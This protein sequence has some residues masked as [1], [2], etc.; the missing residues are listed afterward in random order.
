MGRDREILE[1]EEEGTGEGGKGV[2]KR[3]EGRDLKSVRARVR[4]R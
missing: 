4:R 2:R 1:K 3:W